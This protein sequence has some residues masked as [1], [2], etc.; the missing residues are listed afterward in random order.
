MARMI[1]SLGDFSARSTINDPPE[2][3]LWHQAENWNSPIRV[4]AVNPFHVEFVSS[5]DSGMSSSE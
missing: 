3:E 4:R 1:V 5:T 2:E